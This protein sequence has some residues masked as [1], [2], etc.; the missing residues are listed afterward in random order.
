M[1]VLPAPFGPKKAENLAAFDAK[2]DVVDGGDPAVLF[3]EVLNL[4][5]EGLLMYSL[6]ERAG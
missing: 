3:G 1:V 2:A 6:K 4:N 5:H